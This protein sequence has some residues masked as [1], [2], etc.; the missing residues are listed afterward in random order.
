MKKR[1]YG[2]FYLFSHSA[3][4]Y[5]TVISVALFI[6]SETKV[7]DLFLNVCSG[8]ECQDLFLLSAEEAQTLL[9]IVGFL[10]SFCLFSF[11]LSF[12]WAASFMF[13]E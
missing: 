6:Y 8:E 11:Y 7:Y 12:Q 2:L 4:W 10:L 5:I 9:S 13:M 3:W 1:L